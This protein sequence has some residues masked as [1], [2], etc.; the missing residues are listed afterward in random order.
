MYEVI[1]L[2][3][4]SHRKSCLLV[5]VLSILRQLGDQEVDRGWLDDL[6]VDR[7]CLRVV[8]IRVVLR[9]QEVVLRVREVVLYRVVLDL[10]VLDLVVH[11]DLEVVLSEEVRR[12]ACSSF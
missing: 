11:H 12:L 10:V 8:L 1:C 9:V 2:K 3:D 6:V 4:L 5:G 7:A